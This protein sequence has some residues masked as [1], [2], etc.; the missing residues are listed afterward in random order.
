MLLR[1]KSEELI[2]SY[3]SDYAYITED[4]EGNTVDYFDEDLDSMYWEECRVE[5]DKVLTSK[6]YI[7]IDGM[8]GSWRGSSEIYKIIQSMD[9]GDLSRYLHMED[10]SINVH[11]DRVSYINHGHDA[12][13]SYD[14][15]PMELMDLSKSELLELIYANDYKYDIGRKPKYETKEV[16][17]EYLE[18]LGFD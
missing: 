13:S 12:T 17:I 3:K 10:V 18:E 2:S 6:S 7:M 5:M 1:N 8:A 14:F 15:I 4:E 9:F 16:L 11:P